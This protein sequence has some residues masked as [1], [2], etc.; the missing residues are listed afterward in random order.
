MCF[1]VVV[2]FARPIADLMNQS[3]LFDMLSTGRFPA[4]PLWMINVSAHAP[5]RIK[6]NAGISACVIFIFAVRI[7]DRIAF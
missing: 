2:D 5:L 7:A 3:I 6:V 4:C 1:L